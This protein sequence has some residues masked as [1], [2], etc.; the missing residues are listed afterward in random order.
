MQITLEIPDDKA[1]FFMEVLKNF[2]FVKV[3]NKSKNV[4][5]DKQKEMT[6]QT[7]KKMEEN[8]NRLSN[9]EDVLKRLNPEAC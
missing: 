3:N 7:M 1:S 5:T 8:L 6:K 2:S 4:L 9:W